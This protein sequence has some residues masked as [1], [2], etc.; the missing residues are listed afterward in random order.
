MLKK[1]VTILDG[2]MGTMLQK[3]G[4]SV[5]KVPEVLN[6]THPSLIASIHRQYAQAGSQVIYTNTFGVNR[7]KIEGCGFSCRQLIFEAVRNARQG[8]EGFP[9]KIMLSCGPIGTLMEPNGTLSVQEAYDIFREIMEAGRDAGVDGIVMETFTDLLEIKTAVLAAKECTSLPVWCTMSFEAN[10]R[11]FTGVSLPSMAVTLEGLGVDAIGI[12]CSLGPNEILPM[13]Q[14]LAKYTN[15][16]LIAKPN[17]G[18]PNL[19]TDEYDIVPQEFSRQMAPFLE[20]GVSILGGCCGTT[21]EYIA[22]LSK[23]C[24]SCVPAQREPVE[25]SVLCSG[26]QAVV[27]D[28][29]RVIGERINPTGKKRFKEAL[30]NGNIGYILTQGLE[31][32]HAG[33]HILDVN[34]GLPEIDEAQMMCTVVKQLQS[35]LDVP[36]Q[37]DTN[38]ANVLEKALRLYNGKPIVNS[39]NGET[40]VLRSILPLVKKYGAAVVGLTLDENGIPDTP[41]GRFQIAEKIVKEAEA[42]GIPRRDIYI[43]CLTMTA[44]VQPESARITLEAMDLVKSRLGVKTVLGVSNISFGLP[45]RELI[46]TSFLTLAMEHGLDLPILNPNAACMM[47][48]IHAFAVLNNQ[49]PGCAQYIQH[50]IQD[51]AQPAAAPASSLSLQ[52]AVRDG[53]KET[54]GELVK[55]LLLSKDPMDIVNQE[56][57]PALDAVGNAFENGTL[58]LPQLIQAAGA[59]QCG[60]E[61][62]RKQLSKEAHPSSVS[63]GKIVLA[64]VKG[65]IHDIGKN[66][67]K[68]ILENYGYDIIDLG[69]DVPPETVV[70]ETLR[71]GARLVGLSALM[72]TTLPGMEETIRLLRKSTSCTIMVGGAVLTEEYALSI[73]ADYY[74]KDAKASADIAK[75]VLG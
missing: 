28:G 61:E 39:V 34:V 50:H 4:V 55:N 31:Q 63:K 19:S 57:I 22:L 29:V 45:A 41:L 72:T 47:D 59:A 14:E 52:E 40:A 21:P 9:V 67:V 71:T 3:S 24:G 60:F 5:G 53:L 62:I 12:N 42:I 16:P 11:T 36:L 43:D 25:L 13:I 66:I 64:T 23:C 20:A 70:Q 35:V 2:A 37:L 7:K 26:S 75:K 51:T 68:V 44:S 73:G 6:I 49:D 17:A 56:L 54:V 33:A 15:L 48:A 18:L 46:N 58:F 30:R 8:T 74:A 38:D 69:K 10:G 65:D 32:V 1:T 27:I